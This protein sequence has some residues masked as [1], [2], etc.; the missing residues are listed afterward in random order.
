MEEY[1]DSKKG[2]T[3]ANKVTFFR[4]LCLPLFV[5]SLLYY[6]YLH[7]GYIRWWAIAI[8]LLAVISDVVDG[9]IARVKKERTKVGSL[10]D[11]LADK[12]FLSIAFLTLYIVDNFSGGI[13]IPLWV[14]LIVISR[15]I[16]MLLGAAIILIFKQNLEV[17]PTVW[18]KLTTFFQVA[19]V[20]CILIQSPVARFF[21]IIAGVITVVS[22]TDY[23]LKGIRI[24]NAAELKSNT[25]LPR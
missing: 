22:G 12:F 5:A 4:I 20:F 2:M 8:F 14:V 11:P 1:Y 15:D 17:V 9:Y 24:L 3:F 16:I 21:W 7:K 23:L 10:L 19:T 25:N 18:G 13:R 6:Y